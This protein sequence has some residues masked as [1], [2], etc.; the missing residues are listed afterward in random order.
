V[1]CDQPVCLSVCLSIC[2]RAYLWNRWTDRHEILRADRHVR[3]SALP[4]WRR[5][6]LCTSG[7]VDEATFG[8]NGRDTET[9]RLHR[10]ATAM[11]GVVI[12][13]WSLMRL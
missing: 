9:W 2:S 11:N 4:W 7:I 1:C 13:G 6:T 3:G 12:P 10:A 8:R 5:D